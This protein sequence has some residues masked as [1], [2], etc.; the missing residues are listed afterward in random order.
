M[1]LTTLSNGAEGHREIEERSCRAMA[2]ATA[3][4]LAWMVDPD[5]VAVDASGGVGEPPAKRS[6]A[7]SQQKPGA[8]ERTEA[9][10]KDEG[11]TAA[12]PRKGTRA[13]ELVVGAYGAFDSSTLPAF[14]AGIGAELGARWSSLRV[15]AR[16]ALWAHQNAYVIQGA[17][18]AGAELGL[19]TIGV[20]ACVTPWRWDIAPCAGPELD[21]IQGTGF[22][23]DKPRTDSASWISVGLGVEGRMG[24]VGPLGVTLGLRLVVPT[25]RETFG[26]DEVGN[27][28]RVGALTGRGAVGLQ[29]V[30]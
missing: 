10:P 14:A 11:A 12:A 4:I 6:A 3:V 13:T 22:G 27:V 23:V 5:A 15:L 26:L 24:L 17:R 25:H 1:D 7:E 28:H 16:G 21:R 18:A 8:V 29:A 30:F 19:V 20:D 9:A 2:E